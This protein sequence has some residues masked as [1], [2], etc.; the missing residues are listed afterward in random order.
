MNMG[1]GQ[2]TLSLKNTMH[3]KKALGALMVPAGK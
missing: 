1:Y 3:T 2:A